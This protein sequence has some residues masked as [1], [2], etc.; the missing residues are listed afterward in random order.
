M[1]KNTTLIIVAPLLRTNASKSEYTYSFSQPIP[2]GTLVL[3]PFGKQ[4]IQGIVLRHE[5][6]DNTRFPYTIKHLR[7]IVE[8]EHVNREQILFAST[9]SDRVFCPIGQVLELF[10]MP[11]VRAGTKTKE[12]PK[13]S[14]S[15]QTRLKKNE[16][17]IAKTLNTRTSRPKTFSLTGTFDARTK[18]L[19]ATI[20]AI[21]K[22]KFHQVLLLFP[23]QL[24]A[25]DYYHVLE[26]HLGKISVEFFHASLSKGKKRTIWQNI[27]NGSV[28]V[29]IGL[30]SALFLPFRS[31][32][33]VIIED[34]SND[35]HKQNESHPRYDTKTL[36]QELATIHG[37]TC[38]FSGRTPSVNTYAK[39]KEKQVRAFA[40]PEKPLL[41]EVVNMFREKT[42]WQQNSSGA[43]RTTRSPL[44]ISN[45]LL[46]AIR[47]SLRQKKL[48][49]LLMPRKGVSAKSICAD[50]KKTLTCPECR[51]PLVLLPD[52]RFGCR[53]CNYKSDIFP[54]CPHC[55]SLTFFHRKLGTVSMEQRLH[56]LF[57]SAHILRI[58]SDK[59]VK[60]K[61]RAEA[62]AKIQEN[63]CDI[64]IGSYM[65]A[66]SWNLP[67][68]G[69]IGIIDADNFFSGTNF[70]TDEKAF[71]VFER[72]I[73]SLEHLH[74]H[75]QA[76]TIQANQKDLP[77][78]YIQTFY[79]ENKA[80][81][82]IKNQ[83]PELFLEEEQKNR[84]LLGF[85]PY[86]ILLEIRITDRSQKRV[87]TRTKEVYTQLEHLR[88]KSKTEEFLCSPPEAQ[89]SRL[90][91]KQKKSKQEN[92]N[93]YVIRIRVKHKKSCDM[94]PKEL[95]RF[96]LSLP[97]YC[98]VSRDPL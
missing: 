11:Y 72:F 22:T 15:R 88:N 95:D 73:S 16:K 61:Q 58:D 24:M 86:G 89:S 27:K 25:E 60:P 78:A 40:L 79:P 3:I 36:A 67:H 94:L 96:L 52:E 2:V 91:V 83:N 59:L 30:R 90:L 50:C 44:L 42:P 23:D 31:L 63:K 13:P 39:I 87:E 75:K 84:Q 85:V 74:K 14:P 7:S 80:L 5:D 62:F 1:Q 54:K 18:V 82:A 35:A 4:T 17:L 8:I 45:G 77:K 37:A 57:R 12:K 19:L 51:V 53:L 41:V 26:S 9:L 47:G 66:R 48:F 49:L 98:T 28:R 38:V 71:F 68:L 93:E 69:G 6:R 92:R 33:L 65:L 76:G 97:S 43:R 55:G 46:E 32:K 64:V 20:K 29:V 56:K 81:K 10:L 21:G 70:R 34:E